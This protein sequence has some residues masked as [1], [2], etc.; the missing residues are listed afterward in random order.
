MAM[1]IKNPGFTMSLSFSCVTTRDDGYSHDYITT[2]NP[3]VV[4]W[5]SYIYI[6]KLYTLWH[7]LFLLCVDIIYIYVCFKRHFFSRWIHSTSRKKRSVMKPATRC[8][9]ILGTAILWRRGCTF[10]DLFVG[11]LVEPNRRFKPSLVCWI[12]C[13]GDVHFKKG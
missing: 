7:Y 1:P 4:M 9:D 10:W 11:F 5:L 8:W 13:G 12:A 2:I 6:W 3:N